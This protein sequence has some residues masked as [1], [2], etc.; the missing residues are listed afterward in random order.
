M[1]NVSVIIVTMGTKNYINS[2]LESIFK[3]THLLFEVIVIDNSSTQSLALEINKLYPSVKVYPGAKDSFYAQA[4]NQGIGLSRGEFILCLNDDV[5][6]DKDFIRQALS[7]F[8]VKKNIGLVSGKILRR[9]G[10]TLDSTGLFLSAWR[11]A[12]ERG[13]GLANSGQFEQGGFIFGVNGAAAFYRKEMLEEVKDKNGYFDSRF[14][15]FYEDLDLSWRAKKRGWLAY[16]IPTAVANHVRGG[17]FRPDSGIDKPVARRYLSDEL[18]CGLI[19]NR[20]LTI[21]KNET[22]FGFFLHLIP[23]LIYDLCAWIFVLFF[24][25]KVIKLFFSRLFRKRF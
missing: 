1:T 24:Q 18:H 10:K 4:L 21:L 9:D 11:T 15:M 7:G 2:C 22:F 25:P 13:Y 19:E 20:Y 5:I 14:S 8:S 16:Y 23:I 6:L 12:K 17:S 3:Q